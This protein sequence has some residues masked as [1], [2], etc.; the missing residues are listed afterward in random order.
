MKGKPKGKN[1]QVENMQLWFIIETA[2]IT[3]L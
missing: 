1:R 3:I 2:W